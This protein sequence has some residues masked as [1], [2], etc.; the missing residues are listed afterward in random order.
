[1]LL[2]PWKFLSSNTVIWLGKPAKLELCTL[3]LRY[4]EATYPAFYSNDLIQPWYHWC[5]AGLCLLA[6][7]T[8]RALSDDI[9][10]TLWIV[11]CMGELFFDHTNH[12]IE[13]SRASS[14]WRPLIWLFPWLQ[15][16]YRLCSFQPANL[17]YFLGIPNKR[18]FLPWDLNCL[19]HSL[20]L[21]NY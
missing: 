21:F 19:C 7:E 16:C 20:L 13:E 14:W 1:M 17:R 8:I 2:I 12:T 15:S 9:M 3:T 6:R 5:F 4:A 18:I 11:L 10:V